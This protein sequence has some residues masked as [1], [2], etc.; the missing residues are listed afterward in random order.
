MIRDA[1]ALLAQKK[2]LPEENMREVMRQILSGVVDTADIVEFLTR[3]N[4]KGES[5][6]EITAA[7]SVMVKHIDAIV[8]DRPNILD[9][10]GTGGDRKG[11]FNISTIT[12]FVAAGAGVT[13]AKHGNRA[14]SSKCGSADL[15][16][17]L[18]VA[19][20]IPKEKIKK[21]LEEIGIA[22]LFAPD[23]HPAMKHVMSARKQIPGK[24]MFNI[25]GPLINPARATNQ[26]IGVYSA[27]WTKTLARVLHNL[28]S[29]HGW[30]C[31]ARMVSMR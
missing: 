17:A 16:E 29:E 12:A 3:L 24:T 28:G 18:G 30:W 4:A 31:M 5:V 6:E 25:L 27:Q 15:L 21:S 20:S 23:L 26:L 8:I 13:V 10:C 19:I 7:V 11:T 1:I 22:F 9:T 14:V 2:D